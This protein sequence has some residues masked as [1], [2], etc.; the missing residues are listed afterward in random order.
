MNLLVFS[1]NWMEPLIKPE[2]NQMVYYP[3]TVRQRTVLV[4]RARGSE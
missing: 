1:E 4:S 2:P 3:E